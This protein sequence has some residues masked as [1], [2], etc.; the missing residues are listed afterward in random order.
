MYFTI[1]FIHGTRND[2]SAWCWTVGA[3]VVSQ[4][5]LQCL[6]L[7]YLY[8][9]RMLTRNYVVQE[10]D[11]RDGVLLHALQKRLWYAA[12]NLHDCD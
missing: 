6:C 8:L 11:V 4:R 12:T 5:F 2:L 9:C 7:L 3:V 10:F 1:C